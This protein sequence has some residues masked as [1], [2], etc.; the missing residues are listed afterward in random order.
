MQDTTNTLNADQSPLLSDMEARVL[1][2][3]MEKQLATPDAYP[4]TLNSLQLACNQKTSREPVTAYEVGPL[5]ACLNDLQARALVSVDWGARAA[6]FDQRLTRVYSMDRAAQALLCIMLLRGPQTLNEL[7]TRTQRLYEFPSTAEIA[8]KLQQLCA[9]TR[10]WFV[11]LPRL[12]GQR[13]DRYAQ[14]F[15]GVPE[16]SAPTHTN[17]QTSG[18]INS[19]MV[20]LQARIAQLERQV[21]ALQSQVIDLGATPVEPE[22]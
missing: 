11:H 19:D 13:E 8:D 22:N 7:L 20:K 6:R 21:A 12:A 1:G 2:A 9:K 16:L 17:E 3:L 18:A 14:L 5:Q 10:P 15:C 4:L